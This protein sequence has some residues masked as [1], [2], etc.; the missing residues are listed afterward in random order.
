MYDNLSQLVEWPDT[1]T[2]KANLPIPFQKHY[3]SVK[4]IID[5]FEVQ[6]PLQLEQRNILKLQKT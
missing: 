1:E 6:N 4:C 5:C 2:Q 3:S